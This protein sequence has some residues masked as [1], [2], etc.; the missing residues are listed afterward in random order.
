MIYDDIPERPKDPDTDEWFG[1]DWGDESR[2]LGT[3]TI[4]TSTWVLE[5]GLTKLAQN[6]TTKIGKVKIRGGVIG[7]GTIKTDNNS[8]RYT[9]RITNEITTNIS[10]EKLHRSID[11]YIKSL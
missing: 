4:A 1:I 11:I 7:G 10:Q 2:Y 3:D 8:S 6:N 5:A 9:Y